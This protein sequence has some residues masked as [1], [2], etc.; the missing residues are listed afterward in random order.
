MPPLLQ[1]FVHKASSF[2]ALRNFWLRSALDCASRVYL[3]EMKCQ[4]KYSQRTTEFAAN[5]SKL[6][7]FHSSQKYSE[8]VRLR[9]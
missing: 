8:S 2:T 9:P 5:Y 3:K 7:L 4:T 1:L 6:L